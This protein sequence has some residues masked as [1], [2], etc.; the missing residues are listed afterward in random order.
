MTNHLPSGQS[1]THCPAQSVTAT[2][3]PV[4]E[5]CSAC[6]QVVDDFYGQLQLRA[7]GARARGDWRTE[8][9]CLDWLHLH[10]QAH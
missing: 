10:D 2:I 3:D 6:G 9:A 4:D 5:T 8:R 1:A 7:I